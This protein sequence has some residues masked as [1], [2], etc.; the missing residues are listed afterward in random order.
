MRSLLNKSTALV[1]CALAVAAAL[2]FHALHAQED[3]LSV[4]LN[5]EARANAAAYWLQ[6]RDADEKTV[7]DERVSGDSHTFR[8]QPGDYSQRI[9]TVN[10]LGTP[11]T[12]SPWQP[13][14]IRVTRTP[15]IGAIVPTGAPARDGSRSVEVRGRYF[16]DHTK[17]FLQ[18]PGKP[19]QEVTVTRREPSRMI[20]LLRP[21]EFQDGRYNLVIQNPRGLVKEKNDTVEII[22]QRIEIP[23]AAQQE[24]PEL[25]NISEDPEKSGPITSGD[26][27]TLIPGL[28]AY[29]RGE[30]GGAWVGALGGMFA[31]I[32][33]EYD[34]GQNVRET[35]ERRPYA[36]Y[37]NNIGLFGYLTLAGNPTL[38]QFGL[39]G[40]AYLHDKTIMQREFARHQR[41][42]AY[43]G[44]AA[45]LTW[46]AHF[47]WENRDRWR[48]T[49]LVPGMTHMQR[50]EN[51]RGALW[52]G[53]LAIA[54]VGALSESNA[55]D[56]E[57]RAVDRNAVGKFFAQPETAIPGIQL[58]G[59]DQTIAVAGYN[60]AHNMQSRKIRRAQ[61]HR[62]NANYLAAATAV[63]YLGQIL[64]AIS[65]KG[66]VDDLSEI[67]SRRGDRRVVSRTDRRRHPFRRSP[68]GSETQRPR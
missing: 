8:L 34:A 48:M 10:R 24:N 6:I 5:W 56:V 59:A 61:A 20:V 22:D 33:A 54:S 29:S 32:L 16:T 12:W 45:V 50:G 37:F 27:R 64:G 40:L 63:L 7:L 62:R 31:L 19:P 44:T 15:L 41:N 36:R 23:E 55:A 14:R 4:R 1:I 39:T 11:G 21:A 60:H 47:I 57:F 53:S 26:W 51:V 28:P 9:A 65:G 38:D 58:L 25:A 42:Q 3:P 17:V 30:N 67:L 35:L 66:G 43:L 49:H 52:M 68:R 2:P 13:L 46:G 18:I